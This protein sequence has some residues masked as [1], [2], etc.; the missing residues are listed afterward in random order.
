[1]TT[2]ITENP[3]GT[4]KYYSPATSFAY[5]YGTDTS[6]KDA[7]KNSLDTIFYP[8]TQGVRHNILPALESMYKNYI[9]STSTSGDFLFQL[10]FSETVTELGQVVDTGI[11]NT[12]AIN[13]SY[14]L[15]INL[16]NNLNS[17]P[18]RF[19]AE[20]CNTLNC[21]TYPL[22]FTGPGGVKATE[23]YNTNT[24]FQLRLS[25]RFS[26]SSTSNYVL[27]LESNSS[28]V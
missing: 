1:M 10:P 8:W 22:H 23:L 16:T 11:H 12:N 14:Y 26:G 6:I 4:M 27:A 21:Q 7:C 20:L 24:F 28:G 15:W 19:Y 5:Q 9:T 18:I 17:H 25:V 13:H 2:T 3:A